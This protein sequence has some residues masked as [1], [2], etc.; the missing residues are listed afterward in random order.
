MLELAEVLQTYGGWGTTVVCLG[1]VW[2]M[3]VYIRQLHEQ[4]RVGDATAAV[5]AKE[6]TR[7]TVAALIETRDAL[8]AFK[9]A[10][11]ALTRRLE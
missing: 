1:I 8:R 11:E 7:I 10:M 3:A 9:E 5:A 6:D 2:R 4:Q